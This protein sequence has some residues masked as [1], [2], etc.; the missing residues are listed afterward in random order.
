MW[1]SLEADPETRVRVTLVYSTVILGPQSG[2]EEE[3]EKGR[4][5]IESASTNQC[6]L[7]LNRALP[8]WVPVGDN[9]SICLGTYIPDFQLALPTD[10][11]YSYSQKIPLIEKIPHPRGAQ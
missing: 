2:N 4:K 9:V 5:S 6:F 1:V 11:A 3:R 7:G 8:H 10:L